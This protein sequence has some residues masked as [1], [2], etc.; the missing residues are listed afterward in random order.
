M[1]NCCLLFDDGDLSVQA[2]HGAADGIV[3]RSEQLEPVALDVWLSKTSP[4]CV[5]LSVSMVSTVLF[6]LLKMRRR[7][8]ALT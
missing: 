4:V 7:V 1:M 6:F 8:V 2:V 5:S 3:R